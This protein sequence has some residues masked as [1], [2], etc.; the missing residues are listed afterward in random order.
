MAHLDWIVEKEGDMTELNQRENEAI[1]EFVKENHADLKRM[2]FNNA[3]IGDFC[4]FFV[5][6]YAA[7]SEKMIPY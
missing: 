5:W 7:I 4:E 6:A 3:D 1:Y 2:D